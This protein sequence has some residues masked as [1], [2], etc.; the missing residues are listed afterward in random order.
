M[1]TYIQSL[2]ALSMIS[3]GFSD[4][5]LPKPNMEGGQPLMNCLKQRQTQRQFA[6]KEIPKQVL[7]N[8]LWAAQGVNRDDP[9]YRTAPSARNCN[10]IEIYVVTKDGAYLFDPESHE[11]TEHVKGDFRADTGTQDFVAKAPINLVYVLDTKKQESHPDPSRREM[12]A[13]CDAGFIGQNVYLFC[14]S[15][16]LATVFRGLVDKEK[17]GKSLNL[18]ESKKVLYA[19][20]VGYPQS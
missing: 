11:L 10:A 7:S 16:G 15:E 14:A 13:H 8:M 12:V 5:N 2:I 9:D 17:L 6:D 18:P 4:M 20:S 19:Q 1:K 3:T